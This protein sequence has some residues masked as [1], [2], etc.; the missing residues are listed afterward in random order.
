[1]IT[2][3]AFR[4]AWWLPGPHLQTLYPS[5]FRTRC[6]PRLSRQRLELPDG[7]FVDLDWTGGTGGMVVLVLHGLEGNLE[8]HYTGAL[9]KVLAQRG[10]TAGLLYFRN[11]S[12]EPN[13]LPRSYHSGD[14][15]DLDFVIRHIQQA[16]PG[17]DIAVIGYSLGGNVLLK[18]LGE[19][20]AAAPVR[21]AIAISV[22]FDLN[23]AA[24]KLETG[25]SR[26]YQRHLLKKLTAAVQRK[27]PLHP[28]PVP[29]ERLQELRTF[30]QFDNAIT[31]PLNG[32]K[33]VDDYYGHSSCGQ[34][35]HGIRTPTLIIQSRDDPFLPAAALPAEDDLGPAVVLEL[36]RR[37]GHVGFITGPNPLRPCYWLEQRILQHLCEFD[38]QHQAQRLPE[39]NP[40]TNAK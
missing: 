33:D 31:A 30:R 18:W 14:T 36:S 38:A 25:L 10:Y 26:I 37:G 8:S 29:M 16:F 20:A 23:S 9:L 27:A 21:T 11:C 24:L 1:V 40:E 19:Q 3:S 4:P 32:F 5:L 12:G 6:A 7:D 15:G 35:L 22:P 34:Y 13:R 39:T 28:P 17:R 2:S